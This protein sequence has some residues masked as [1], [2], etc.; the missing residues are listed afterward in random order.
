MRNPA[1]G[2]SLGPRTTWAA[3]SR[4]Q[5]V[6]CSFSVLWIRTGCDLKESDGFKPGVSGDPATR[7]PVPAI[8]GSKPGSPPEAPISC[9]PGLSPICPCGMPPQALSSNPIPV[10]S[11]PQ[12]RI[13][14]C[15]LLAPSGI[16]DSP[17]CPSFSPSCSSQLRASVEWRDR[18]SPRSMPPLLPR[19]AKTTTVEGVSVPRPQAAKRTATRRLL[20]VPSRTA[21]RRTPTG[22]AFGTR[23]R[24]WGIDWSV[25]VR[26]SECRSS[27]NCRERGSE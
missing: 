19:T 2:A 11:T 20:A 9:L 5:R 6:G 3:S 18:R 8:N 7:L 22:T 12:R 16:P 1:G 25:R 15:H 17:R 14:Q 21:D 13:R 27:P 4:N 26:R 10:S 24:M 23:V